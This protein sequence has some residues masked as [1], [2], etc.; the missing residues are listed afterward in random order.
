MPPP[1]IWREPTPY[2]CS[3]EEQMEVMARQ[4]GLPEHDPKPKEGERK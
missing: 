1:P 4:I 2:P 3:R